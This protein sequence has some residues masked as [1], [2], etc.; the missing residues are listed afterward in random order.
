MPTFRLINRPS[1][2]AGL[3]RPIGVLLFS[4]V[5][6]GEVS[7]N[8]VVNPGFESA[9]D[10]VLDWNLIGENQVWDCGEAHTGSCSLTSAKSAAGGVNATYQ[11]FDTAAGQDYAV[12]FFYKANRNA[13]LSTIEGRVDVISGAVGSFQSVFTAT[14]LGGNSW[15]ASVGSFQATGPS[16]RISFEGLGFGG[17]FPG[18]GN[19]FNVDDVQVEPVPLP[20]ALWSMGLALGGLS[21]MRRR[22][23]DPHV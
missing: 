3:A 9:P 15:A 22:A 21:F 13:P 7:A 1:L 20:A 4:L 12:S 16:T 8:M 11:F 18:T 5:A 10:E 17:P 6:A 19:S 2:S 14:V 23:S